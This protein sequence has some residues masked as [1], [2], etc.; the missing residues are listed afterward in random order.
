MCSAV[1]AHRLYTIRSKSA[2]CMAFWIG[3]RLC[4]PTCCVSTDWHRFKN[5]PINVQSWLFSATWSCWNILL[6]FQSPLAA[7]S[8]QHSQHVRAVCISALCAVPT[9]LAVLIQSSWPF[10]VAPQRSAS[11]EFDVGF[12]PAPFPHRDRFLQ[13]LAGQ[14]RAPML[15]REASEVTVRMD[16]QDT[17]VL[18]QLLC[19]KQ[20][21]ET[22]GIKFNTGV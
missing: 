21:Q 9:L 8:V 20:G 17:Q 7:C 16:E 5:Q 10:H 18:L 11:S 15:L 14:S 3:V 19:M 4:I 22:V 6:L 1:L 2:C 12:K 13:I